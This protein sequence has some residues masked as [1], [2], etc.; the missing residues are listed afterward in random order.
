M[1]H[2][3]DKLYRDVGQRC[4]G[5]MLDY[6]VN[7][8]SYPLE[9]AWRF[10]L[11]SEYSS[12]FE[13]GDCSIL[14]GRSGTELAKDV[15]YSVGMPVPERRKNFPF[16]RSPEYWTGWAIAYYQWETGMNFSKITQ[17]VH[18][19]DIRAM[20]NPYHEMDIR[21]FV[22][23][24]NAMYKQAHPET[25][26]KTIRLRNSMSQTQL[27]EVSGVSVRT[28]QQYEQRRKDINK[29]SAS[30]LLSMARVLGCRM[31]DLLELPLSL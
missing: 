4:L 16:E 26:L 20:Y 10:F 12:R 25:M 8:L 13:K 27:A 30:T 1:T 19:N 7:D 24:M 11:V 3:Y 2:A 29:S 23:R 15:L 14:A 9:D 22:D 17:A 31:E 18:I 28:I 5:S 21:H 6:L